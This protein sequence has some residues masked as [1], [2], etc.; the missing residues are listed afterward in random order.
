MNEINAMYNEAVEKVAQWQQDETFVE[1]VNAADTAEKLS[2]LFAEKGETLTVEEAQE[3]LDMVQDASEGELNA[4]D[5]DDV[6]GGGFIGALA[7][8]GAGGVLT[9]GMIHVLK[10]KYPD[11]WK[12][13]VNAWNNRYK[14]K[15]NR[16]K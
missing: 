15:K 11:T 10:H 9:V 5:L 7:I 14:K 16:K 3:V 2:A 12:T 6:S 13:I 8:V 4:E 1:K